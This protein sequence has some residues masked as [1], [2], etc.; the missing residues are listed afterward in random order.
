MRYSNYFDN[1]FS[2]IF[3]EYFYMY[4]IQTYDNNRNNI[5]LWSSILYIY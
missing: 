2:N 3:T 4:G 1:K 5:S